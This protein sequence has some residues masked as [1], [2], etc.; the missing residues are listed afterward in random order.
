[1]VEQFKNTVGYDGYMVSNLGRVFSKK[2]DQFLKQ[3]P[4]AKGYYRVELCVEGKAKNVAVH[5]LVAETFLSNPNNLPI[6]NHKDENKQNNCVENLEWC[7]HIYNSNYGLCQVKKAEHKK[8]PVLQLSLTTGEIVR[9]F[10][11]LKEA[12]EHGF[13]H[14]NVSA[15]CNGRKKSAYGF[16]WKLS[17]EV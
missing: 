10:E 1:M 14:S 11:S 13:N 16:C 3:T 7:T 9:R 5:R 17:L 15:C 4:N 6:I 12:E 2:T 8:K